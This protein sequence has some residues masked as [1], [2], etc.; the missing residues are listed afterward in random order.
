MSFDIQKINADF[1]D[2]SPQEFLQWAVG[3]FYPRITM[4]S[5]FG[6]EDMALIDMFAG[7]AGRL[8]LQDKT[9]RVFTLDTGRLNEE[10]YE[11]IDRVRARYKIAIESYFPDPRKVEA[12]ERT[13]GFYSFRES[14]ENRK[15][16]CSIRKVGPL[17]RAL[18]G[19]AA[20]ITG[21]R[22]D[23]SVTRAGVQK[24]EVDDAHNGI[25]KIN[26]LAAW[27]NDQVW[28]Y[29][30]EQGVPY[31]KLHELGYSSIGCAPC[32]RAIKPGENIRDGRWWWESPEHK[33]CGLHLPKREKK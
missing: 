6:A 25:F 10:T 27:T 2:K 14:L 32:T 18:Q 19:T 9:I 26:P 30:R 1:A 28:Q 4:A 11:L 5:S 24:I 23:Q 33:E 13:K 12:L 21:L 29:L 17:A 8:A 15:E 16:C 7:P 22:R 20:W 3:A 31:S